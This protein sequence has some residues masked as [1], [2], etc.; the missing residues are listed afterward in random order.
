MKNFTVYYL[1][2]G[3][4]N[5]IARRLHNGYSEVEANEE[6]ESLKKMG[7]PAMKVEAEKASYLGG[8]CSHTEFETV[9]ARRKYWEECQINYL[10]RA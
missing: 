4:E 5:F 3:Y 9:A 8:M 1:V 10:P 7:Y 2:G 6:V